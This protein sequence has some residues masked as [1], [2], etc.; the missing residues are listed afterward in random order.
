MKKDTDK[1]RIDC[2]MILINTST[3]H[4]LLW[5]KELWKDIHT[6]TDGFIKVGRMTAGGPNNI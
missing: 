3:T 5:E 2:K 4:L 1:N 6:G